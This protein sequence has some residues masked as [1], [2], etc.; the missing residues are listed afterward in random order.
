MLE[1]LVVVLIVAAAAWFAVAK[2]LPASLRKRLG[3]SAAKAGCGS[4]CDN[5]SSNSGGG[6]NT[7]CSDTAAPS[8]PPSAHRVIRIHAHG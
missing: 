5:C 3:L 8:Q 7:G 1:T 6:G 4:G 2:Y